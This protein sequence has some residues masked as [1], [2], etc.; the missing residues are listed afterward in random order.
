VRIKELHD[1][2]KWIYYINKNNMI[3]KC[4]FECKTSTGKFYVR[5][6]NKNNKYNRIHLCSD[7]IFWTT[8]QEVQQHLDKILRKKS[9]KIESNN[10][11]EK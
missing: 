9:K 7:T 4:Q 11:L 8:K 5:I 3:D 2:G 6:L 1:S 10:N